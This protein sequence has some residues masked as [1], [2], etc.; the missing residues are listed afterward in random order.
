MNEKYIEEVKKEFKETVAL[1]PEQNGERVNNS[2]KLVENKSEFYWDANYLFKAEQL[3]EE[4][5][6]YNFLSFHFYIRNLDVNHF[7]NLD[8]QWVIMKNQY[9]SVLALI[10]QVNLYFHYLNFLENYIQNNYCF[11][12]SN[13]TDKR[14]LSEVYEACQ[15]YLKGNY[16]L[17]YQDASN[18]ETPIYVFPGSKILDFSKKSDFA[19]T[20]QWSNEMY[21]KWLAPLALASGVW[22]TFKYDFDDKYVDFFEAYKKEIMK[23]ATIDNDRKNIESQYNNIREGISV[24]E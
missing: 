22:K 2:D 14:L 16:L 8:F 17:G 4:K 6:D 12:R 11:D 9:E 24:K 3:E 5:N 19:S 15:E 20:Y 10:K 21:N 13:E 18:Q 1:S 23:L 7:Y